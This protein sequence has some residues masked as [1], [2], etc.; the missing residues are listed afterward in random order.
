MQS[1]VHLR[2]NVLISHLPPRT[3]AVFS[4]FSILIFPGLLHTDVLSLA[5]AR[6]DTLH[7]YFSDDVVGRDFLFPDQFVYRTEA[8]ISALVSLLSPESILDSVQ[9]DRVTRMFNLI[10]QSALSIR[11][12]YLDSAILR[13]P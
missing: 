3:F 10:A 11:Y 7:T 5:L 13:S 4:T 9:R 6:D 2:K 12:L 1:E 8:C